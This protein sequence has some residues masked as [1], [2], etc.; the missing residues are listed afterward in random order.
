M[1]SHYSFCRVDDLTKL[2]EDEVIA[3]QN[4]SSAYPL[5]DGTLSRESSLIKSGTGMVKSSSGLNK[6]KVCLK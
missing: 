3:D 6:E 5:V 2:I 1:K 4:P